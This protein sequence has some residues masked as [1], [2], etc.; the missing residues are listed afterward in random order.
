MI[1]VYLD[2]ET[3]IFEGCFYEVVMSYDMRCYERTT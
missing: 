3:D 1:F 2:N